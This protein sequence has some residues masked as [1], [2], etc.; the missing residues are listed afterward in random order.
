MLL[1]PVLVNILYLRAFIIEDRLLQILPRRVVK[2]SSCRNCLFLEK[3]SK[4]LFFIYL[5][6]FTLYLRFYLGN[7]VLLRI[8]LRQA[9]LCFPGI[10][11]IPLLFSS[12]FIWF[13]SFVVPYHSLLKEAMKLILVYF[14]ECGFFFYKIVQ[15]IFSFFKRHYIHESIDFLVKCRF[16][17]LIVVFYEDINDIIKIL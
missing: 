15:T 1:N 14:A 3:L 17:I 10:P 5:I 8:I 16:V 9:L 13:L 7:K 2:T 4:Y 11:V 12:L 6:L